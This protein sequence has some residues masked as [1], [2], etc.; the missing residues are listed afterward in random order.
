MGIYLSIVLRQMHS[1][2]N[3]TVLIFGLPPPSPREFPTSIRAFM[4]AGPEPLGRPPCFS[5]GINAGVRNMPINL[6]SFV[7]ESA[8]CFRVNKLPDTLI[9]DAICLANFI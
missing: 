8:L 3:V 5:L 6:A 4:R 7:T 2:T 1:A 9:A